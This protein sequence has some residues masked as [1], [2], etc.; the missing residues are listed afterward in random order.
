M[1]NPNPRNQFK[2]GKSG[3]VNG[4]P[5]VREEVREAREVN[6]TEFTILINYYVRMPPA[7]STAIAKMATTDNL[8]IIVI[9]AIECARKGDMRALNLIL[10]R[11]IGPVK[12]NVVQALEHKGEITFAKTD[13]T[14]RIDLLKSSSG[15]GA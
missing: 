14:E 3:N 9:V 10:D 13:L 4:R 1:S 15:E 11:M 5:K 6:D 8:D 12:I 7:K 2:R